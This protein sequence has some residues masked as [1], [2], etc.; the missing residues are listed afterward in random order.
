MSSDRW[1]IFLLLRVIVPLNLERLLG[2]NLI[3]DKAIV[4]LPQPDSPTIPRAS[5]G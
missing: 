4:V 2:N 3:K 5:P 1:L